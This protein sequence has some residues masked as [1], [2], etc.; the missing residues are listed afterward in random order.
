[1]IAITTSNSMSVK[2]ACPLS[3]F[4]PCTRLD[5]LPNPAPE[6]IPLL[7]VLRNA[8]GPSKIAR[9][10]LNP[11]SKVV[12]IRA[13]A[14]IDQ[15]PAESMVPPPNWYLRWRAER[16][17]RFRFSEGPDAIPP[18]ALLQQ[19]WAYQRVNPEKL[20]AADGRRVRI[21]HPGFLNREAGPDFRGAIVQVGDDAPRSGDVEIDLVPAGWEHHSHASNSAY[22]NVVLHV[23]WEPE[24][25]DRP[26]PS[27]ALK[28]ALDSSLPDLAFWLGVQPKPQPEG[29]AGQCSAP[30]RALEPARV[31][32]I[33]KQAAQARL[34]T[35]AEQLQARARQVG[36]EGALWEGLFSAL[37]YKRNVWPMRRLAELRSLR[38]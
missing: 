6:A 33:L 23:T 1:M 29:L 4:T 34:R 3:V 9:E 17:S 15:T 8:Q 26:F 38:L 10:G 24:K 7:H 22:R 25:G 30:L 12:Q 21:L 37:G 11:F 31:R 20:K 16:F 32:E 14:V 18:E 13:L 2:P 35:K 27:V 5:I 28:Y 36:W 19:V